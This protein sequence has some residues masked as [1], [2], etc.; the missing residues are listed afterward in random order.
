M[1]VLASHGR[2]GIFRWLE[3]SVAEALLKDT[4]GPLLIIPP[5]VAQHQEL[6]DLTHS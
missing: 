5:A 3:G 4:G 6:G 1:I 2:S